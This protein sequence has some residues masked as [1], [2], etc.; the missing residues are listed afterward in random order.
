MLL[1]NKQNGNYAKN[2]PYNLIPSHWF[3][4]KHKTSQYDGDN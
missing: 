1:D 4:V 2:Y 3:T